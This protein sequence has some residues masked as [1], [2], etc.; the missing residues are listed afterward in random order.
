MLLS[1]IVPVHNNKN[2]LSKCINSLVQQKINSHDVEVIMVENGSTDGSYELGKSISDRYDNVFLYKSENVG[3]SC[4]RNVGLRHAKGDLIGFCDADDYFKDDAFRK[5]IHIYNK[6]SADT[7]VVGI[8]KENSKNRGNTRRI[9]IVSGDELIPHVLNDDNVMGSV[10]NK[11]YRREVIKDV[12]F[13]EGLSHCEDTYFN[14]QVLS[15]NKEARCALYLKPLYTYNPNPFSATRCVSGLFDCEDRLKYTVACKHIL[16]DFA[17][18][19]KEKRE[20]GYAITRLSLECISEVYRSLD[21][22][23]WGNLLVDIRMNRSA[24]LILFMK[25][26]S[27]HRVKTLVLASVAMIRYG[28]HSA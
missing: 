12:L 25:Y 1:I 6:L 16:K 26:V 11:F 17:L 28:I 2:T 4:A 5:V 20:L 15:T 7:I 8:E 21:N 14:I 23:K 19:K 22:K 10:C 13:N 24:Y 18:D 27:M 3:V 9:K